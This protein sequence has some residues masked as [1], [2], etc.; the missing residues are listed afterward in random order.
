MTFRT[1][2]HSKVHNK[3]LMSKN[4]IRFN[5]EF[6]QNLLQKLQKNATMTLSHRNEDFI[7]F[8]FYFVN[9]L[10]N[11]VIVFD[12]KWSTFPGYATE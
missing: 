2:G 5:K 6:C 3:T 9:M 8:S 11:Q 1:F 4:V 12:K 7:P 10:L